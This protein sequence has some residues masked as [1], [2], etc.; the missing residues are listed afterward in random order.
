[1]LA[2]LLLAAQPRLSVRVDTPTRPAGLSVGRRLP[3]RRPR[4]LG[5]SWAVRLVLS[6]PF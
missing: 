1:M 4:V 5:G 6:L 2:F 3:P